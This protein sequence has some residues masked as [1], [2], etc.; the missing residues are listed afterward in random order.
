MKTQAIL[1][2]EA[3]ERTL[4]WFI[5][6]IKS[7][8]YREPDVSDSK[9]G[10]TNDREILVRDRSH[11]EFLFYECQNKQGKRY[12]TKYNTKKPI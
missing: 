12:Y 5:L 4:D 3:K 10:F 8:I 11:A 2:T 1:V 6:C 9:H 7:K